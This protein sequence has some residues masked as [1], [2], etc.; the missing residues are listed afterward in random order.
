MLQLVPRCVK[1]VARE[2]V[3]VLVCEDQ[4]ERQKLTQWLLNVGDLLDAVSE[5]RE[6]DS[7]K[8]V[9]MGKGRG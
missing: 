5:S 7:A 1:N 9:F 2:M 6:P 3:L 8:G 4:Q